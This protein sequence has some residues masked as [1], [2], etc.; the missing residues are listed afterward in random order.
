MSGMKGFLSGYL[1]IQ[2]VALPS[3][4]SAALYYGKYRGSYRVQMWN[5]AGDL[6]K[7]ILAPVLLWPMIL[8]TLGERK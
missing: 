4:A 3:Y 8:K 6:T 7:M 5:L 2:A 1:K